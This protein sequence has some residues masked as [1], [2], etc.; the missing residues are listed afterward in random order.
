MDRSSGLK[1]T[2]MI[3]EPSSQQD[4]DESKVHLVSDKKRK[5]EKMLIHNV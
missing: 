5:K 4:G 3:K 2:R 1:D